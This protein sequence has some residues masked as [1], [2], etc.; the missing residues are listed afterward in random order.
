M[1]TGDTINKKKY[2]KYSHSKCSKNPCPY[3]I[4]TCSGQVSFCVGF[5]VSSRKSIIVGPTCTQTFPPTQVPK[6]AAKM[7][8][9]DHLYSI[10]YI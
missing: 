6:H 5:A 8:G 1:G 9:P 4:Q 10:H 7:G 2:L 3:T